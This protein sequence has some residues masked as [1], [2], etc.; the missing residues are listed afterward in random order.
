VKTLLEEY[1]AATKGRSAKGGAVAQVSKSTGKNGKM[2]QVKEI[3]E[4]P[5]EIP[6]TEVTEMT[7]FVRRAKAA[8]TSPTDYLDEYRY[9]L[10]NYE[11]KLRE[12]NKVQIVP[13]DSLSG[14]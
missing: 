11:A 6:K 2:V 4:K 12:L 8:G 13:N 7:G 10:G 9:V 1:S 14:R 5:T 3:G